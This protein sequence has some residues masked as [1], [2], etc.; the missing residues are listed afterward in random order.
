VSEMVAE[1]FRQAR[2]DSVI[3]LAGFKSFD[4]HE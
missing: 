3:K 2:R 1:D 4:H